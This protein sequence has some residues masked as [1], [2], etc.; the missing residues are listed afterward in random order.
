M[1]ATELVPELVKAVTKRTYKGSVGCMFK[2]IVPPSFL[3]DMRADAK[4]LEDVY[5][6]EQV[7][8]ADGVGMVE[9]QFCIRKKATPFLIATDAKYSEDDDGFVQAILANGIRNNVRQHLITL[10]QSGT[11]SGR[12]TPAT[13]EI[14]PA[15]KGHVDVPD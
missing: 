11:L 7:M 1:S 3:T 12:I 5:S 6:T 10:I 9:K 13:V 2:I 15:I 4:V 14:N 8:G